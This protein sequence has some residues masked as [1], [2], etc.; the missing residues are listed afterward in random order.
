MEEMRQRGLETRSEAVYADCV[1]DDGRRGFVVRL[2]RYPEAGFAWV[3]CHLFLDGQVYAFTDHTLACD[4][5]PSVLEADPLRYALAWPEGRVD[6]ERD[7]DRQAPRRVSVAARCAA[8]AVAH[9]PHGNGPIECSIEAVFHPAAGAVSNLPGR[10][11][12]LGTMR[13]TLVVNGRRQ[14]L[15]GRAQFHEQVQ[16]I[17]RFTAPFTYLTLR[18]ADLGLI[19]IRGARGSGGYLLRPDAVTEIVRIGLSPPGSVRRLALEQR[20]GNLLTGELVTAYDYSVPVF[21]GYRPGTLIS[22]SLAGI[23]VTGCVNDYLTDQL[24]FDREHGS[25]LVLQT[26]TV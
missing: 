21:N 6:F 13:A 1:S 16:T 5:S 9:P 25:G 18:G 20:D 22:G 4:G 2:C 26:G 14:I 17:P 12:V 8:H 3:W 7:G 24:S 11:E 19:A 23:A 15:E 10:S